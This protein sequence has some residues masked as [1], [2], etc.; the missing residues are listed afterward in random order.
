MIGEEKTEAAVISHNNLVL[1]TILV[2]DEVSLSEFMGQ[3]VVRN[4]TPH[5]SSQNQWVSEQSLLA[6]LRELFVLVSFERS[7]LHLI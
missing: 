6:I 7:Y 3:S 1:N 5:V 4:R 2:K